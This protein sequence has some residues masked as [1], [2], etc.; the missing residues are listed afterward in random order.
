MLLLNTLYKEV[1]FGRIIEK[2][3]IK[4]YIKKRFMGVTK[5]KDDR[6]KADS[7]PLF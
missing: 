1:S 5:K 2:S 6:S 3:L 7:D 4:L